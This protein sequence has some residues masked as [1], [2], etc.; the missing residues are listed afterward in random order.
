MWICVSFE[1]RRI[2]L[3]H[4]QGVRSQHRLGAVLL[5]L[6]ALRSLAIEIHR[7]AHQPSMR[8]PHSQL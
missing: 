2:E 7:I 3:C 4:A 1:M 6:K 5:L 8:L